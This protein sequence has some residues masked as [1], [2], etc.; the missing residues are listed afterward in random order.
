[1]SVVRPCKHDQDN[2][3]VSGMPRDGGESCGQISDMNVQGTKK[4][5]ESES[6]ATSRLRR[7]QSVVWLIPESPGIMQATHF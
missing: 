6:Q 3:I 4:Q 7:R 2:Q 1:M 5:F